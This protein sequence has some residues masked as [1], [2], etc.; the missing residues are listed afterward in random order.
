MLLHNDT[1]TQHCGRDPVHPLILSGTSEQKIPL[2]AQRPESGRPRSCHRLRLFSH[3]I[4]VESEY[5]LTGAARAR[6]C[7]DAATAYVAA[8]P[9]ASVINLGAGLDTTFYRIDNGSI[10]WYD[11]DL[12]SIIA[13]RKQLL[14]ETDRTHAIAKS[15]LDTSWYGEVTHTKHGVLAIAGG[16]LAY[17]EGG[18]VK[19]FLSALAD[20]VP[21]AEIVFIAYSRHEVSLINKSCS[22]LG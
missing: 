13:L 1:P 2:T 20:H 12:P 16:V 17:F 7:D 14:P 15:L 9:R 5:L 3:R 21:G 4:G 19:T 6:Q 10:E 8:H 18:Q 22:I 11:L